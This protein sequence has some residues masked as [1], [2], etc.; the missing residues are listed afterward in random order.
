MIK[1]KISLLRCLN[2]YVISCDYYIFQLPFKNNRI[3]IL[4]IQKKSEMYLTAHAWVSGPDL[5]PQKFL[6]SQ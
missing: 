6:L 4:E 3:G 2:F 1:K 5:A